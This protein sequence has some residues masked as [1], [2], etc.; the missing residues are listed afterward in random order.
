MKDIDII[1]EIFDQEIYNSPLALEFKISEIVDKRL[2]NGL[3]IDLYCKST[4]YEFDRETITH[5]LDGKKTYDE[6]MSDH[7]YYIDFI[8][9][10]VK[11]IFNDFLFSRDIGYC[12][13][14]RT[15]IK[16]LSNRDIEVIIDYCLELEI[17]EAIPYIKC[18]REGREGEYDKK[19]EK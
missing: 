10:G 9:K 4:T 12:D 1:Y 15:W 7:E 6:A 18:I 5:L 8:S 3:I 16:T 2:S 13:E 17:F 11:P 19:T 14:F